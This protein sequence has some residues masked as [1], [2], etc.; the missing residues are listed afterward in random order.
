M[1]ST[2]TTMTY[3]STSVNESPSPSSSSL[4]SSSSSSN[5]ISTT[6][7]SSSSSR[8]DSSLGLLTKKFISLLRSSRHGDLDLNSAATQL[9]VQKRRIY[10]ITNVLEGIRLIE[11]NS[12]NHVRWIGKDPS[13]KKASTSPG[14]MVA[15]E[16]RAELEHRLAALRKHNLAL[17]KEHDHLMRIK[18]Q[19]EDHVGHA[20]KNKQ[21]YMTMDDI[22]TFPKKKT[23]RSSTTTSSSSKKTKESGDVLLVVNAPLGTDVSFRPASPSSPTPISYPPQSSSSDLHPQHQHQHQ[24]R[25]RHHSPTKS[26]SSALKRFAPYS[27]PYKNKCYIQAPSHSN[28]PI[29]VI[30]LSSSRKPNGC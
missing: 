26:S 14:G 11:K 18:R 2:T 23:K 16:K 8:Y 20:L 12:K 4:S 21:C 1:N 10:D 28:Q 13:F 22:L 27:T 3:H 17:E 29:R 25:H 15:A 30:T 9:K 6:T 5:T 19:T 7:N 24:H